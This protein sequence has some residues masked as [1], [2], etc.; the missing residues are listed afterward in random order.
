M[1][2][3]WE[4]DRDR[5]K[6]V[7]F[8]AGC[9][10]PPS[11]KCL[12]PI[13][14]GKRDSSEWRSASGLGGLISCDPA[15]PEPG[16]V[17]CYFIFLSCKHLKGIHTKCVKH[18]FC[19]STWM[20]NGKLFALHIRTL[21]LWLYTLCVS[22]LKCLNKRSIQKRYSQGN[23]YE[24]PFNPK[25]YWTTGAA[26]YRCERCVDNKRMWTRGTKGQSVN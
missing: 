17:Y 24:W 3:I 15:W 4:T 22:R 2:R 6:S 19:F 13:R 11:P 26:H 25:V 16:G 9:H 20:V 5:T 12:N 14:S 18:G 10:P 23:I 21:S 7:G 8:L 1:E